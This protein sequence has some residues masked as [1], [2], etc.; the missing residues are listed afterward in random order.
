MLARVV[1]VSELAHHR[2]VRTTMPLA[3][4]L[5]LALVPVLPVNPCHSP[6][7]DIL[8]PPLIMMRS[9]AAPLEIAPGAAAAA[10]AVGTAV[11]AVPGGTTAGAAP[12]GAVTAATAITIAAAVL[13]T[14]PSH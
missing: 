7:M 5:K 1:A 12:R 6:R 2:Q 9:Q 8:L 10:A 4:W 13:L 14:N 3:Q 11:A